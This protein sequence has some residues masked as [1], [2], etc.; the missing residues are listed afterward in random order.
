MRCL[1]MG[2]RSEKYVVRRFCHRENV[3]ECIYSNLDIT[4]YYTP[5]L[6]AIAYCSLLCY[7]PV[8]Y[9]TVLN[10]VRLVLLR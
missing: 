9:V 2:I 4:A 1:T 10:T 8:Q 3:I 6:Y 7:K 5:S